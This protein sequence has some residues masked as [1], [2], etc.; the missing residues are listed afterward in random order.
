MDHQIQ[1]HT[2]IPLNEKGVAQAS[3]LADALAAYGIDVICSSDLSRAVHT[4]NIIHERSPGVRQIYTPLLRERNWGVIEGKRWPEIESDFKPDAEQIRSGSPDY[5]PAGGESKNDVAAR[6]KELQ[7]SIL[8]ELYGKTILIVA[9]GG[10][11]GVMIRLALGI[12]LSVRTPFRVDNCSIS[13]VDIL[14]DGFSVIDT[15]NNTIHLR[16]VGLL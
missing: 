3:A 8:P 15:L 1:G 6:V 16:E 4:A 10:I 11:C 12:D 13:V 9:H 14:D 2:D 5:A 7:E